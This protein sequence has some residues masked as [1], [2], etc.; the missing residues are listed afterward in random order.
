MST[1]QPT[2]IPPTDPTQAQSQSN[3][4]ADLLLQYFPETAKLRY[5][6]PDHLTSLTYHRD[7]CWYCAILLIPTMGVSYLAIPM[8]P[9]RSRRNAPLPCLLWCF[10]RDTA[11]D[12]GNVQRAW[13]ASESQWGTCRYAISSLSVISVQSA[14]PLLPALIYAMDTLSFCHVSVPVLLIWPLWTAKNM[15]LRER[16]ETLKKETKDAFNDARSLEHR[17]HNEIVPAQDEV[18]KVSTA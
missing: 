18:Y 9:R 5:V 6:H 10:L 2:G 17:W 7:H 14:D 15:A 13:R 11:P 4:P 1:P 12:I 3:D 16:H 8:Q